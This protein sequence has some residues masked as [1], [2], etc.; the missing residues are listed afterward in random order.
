[1]KPTGIAIFD[2][3]QQGFASVAHHVQV[4]TTFFQLGPD[5]IFL[6]AYYRCSYE[7]LNGLIEIFFFD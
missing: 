5:C 3:Q 4:A 1:M 2:A 6:I 7:T